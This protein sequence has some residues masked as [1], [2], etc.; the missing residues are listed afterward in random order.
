[1]RSLTVAKESAI[2]KSRGLLGW[3]IVPALA[4]PLFFYALPRS[5]GDIIRLEL[6]A[7]AA[8]FDGQPLP[9]PSA[10]VL[11]AMR[12]DFYMQQVSI[13]VASASTIAVTL[14]GLAHETCVD[15]LVKARRLEGLSVIALQG[16]RTMQDC[17]STNDMTWWIMP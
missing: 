11:A 17:Q 13:A 6:E 3:T 4:A 8:E 1:M 5:P 16:Y 12:G 2:A 15:A 7:A 9:T 14:H 10:T